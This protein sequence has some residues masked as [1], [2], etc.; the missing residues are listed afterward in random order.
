MCS[1]IFA[2]R[3]AVRSQYQSTSTLLTFLA[4]RDFAGL[5]VRDSAWARAGRR[6]L[7]GASRV[8]L[9]LLKWCVR[10]T[11]S[12]IREYLPV[13]FCFPQ[14]SHNS[15]KSPHSSE[16]LNSHR[17][18]ESEVPSSTRSPCAGSTTKPARK[19]RAS[20]WA[21]SRVP[22]RLGN[23]TLPIADC[24]GPKVGC[25]AVLSDLL[26][27]IRTRCFMARFNPAVCY[28]SLKSLVLSGPF[29]EFLESVI[30]EGFRLDLGLF[31]TTPVSRAVYPAPVTSCAG[32]RILLLFGFQRELPINRHS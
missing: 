11:E 24:C 2:N 14:H 22:M 19:K 12:H 6:L 17:C 9:A 15:A 23:H 25:I 27:I 28:A 30:K 7:R 8:G 31:R 5:H 13:N 3:I 18:R 26:H 29:K 21:V 4:S 10:C 20:I 16:L 32:N 1:P